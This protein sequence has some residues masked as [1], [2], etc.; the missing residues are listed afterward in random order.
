MSSQS[1]AEFDSAETEAVTDEAPEADAEN[2]DL[3]LW[4]VEF[5]KN[6]KGYLEEVRAASAEDAK[7]A[8]LKKYEGQNLPIT[9][10]EITPG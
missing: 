6:K 10:I 5:V 1:S 3:P 7:A 8:I 2:A 4:D 9:F